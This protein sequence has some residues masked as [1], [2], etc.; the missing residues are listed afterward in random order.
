[1]PAGL[2]LSWGTVRNGTVSAAGGHPAVVDRQLLL[3]FIVA[4]W[5]NA[6][7]AVFAGRTTAVVSRG[8]AD[9]RGSTERRLF[10]VS[11]AV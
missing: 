5:I 8:R 2:V 4:A 11:S 10:S 1:M 3:R 9:L 6:L 7:L